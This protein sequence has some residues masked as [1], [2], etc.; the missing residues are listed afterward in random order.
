MAVRPDADDDDT[1]NLRAGTRITA[2]VEEGRKRKLPPAAF[3]TK[4]WPDPKRQEISKA[5]EDGSSR[6]VTGRPDSV[7]TSPPAAAID[8]ESTHLV[9]QA[10]DEE[11]GM[12]KYKGKL[13]DSKG[14]TRHGI[15]KVLRRIEARRLDS[16]QAREKQR[17]DA[18][19]QKEEGRWTPELRMQQEAYERDWERRYKYVSRY[20]TRQELE[21]LQRP[22][23]LENPADLFAF[24]DAMA[25]SSED[26]ANVVVVEEP[27]ES[28][29]DVSLGFA[30]D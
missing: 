17:E 16:K 22:N 1:R 29:V 13:I 15:L 23:L 25:T 20:G 9:S 26:E 24:E 2:V 11:M 5:D 10:Y 4:E 18:R 3:P 19:G 7:V 12:F 21:D 14:R 27:A 6:A 30:F 28:E 8:D